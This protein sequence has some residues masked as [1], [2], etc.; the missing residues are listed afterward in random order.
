MTQAQVEAPAPADSNGEDKPARLARKQARREAKQATKKARRSKRVKLAA[1][2]VL[3]TE[4]VAKLLEQLASGVRTGHVTAKS[5]DRQITLESAGTARVRLKAR[6]GPKKAR[7]S[8]RICWSRTKAE[9]ESASA[10]V[11]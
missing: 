6:S 9:A 4:E 5:S 3:N 1:K 11:A 7:L 10:A 8:V 2:E